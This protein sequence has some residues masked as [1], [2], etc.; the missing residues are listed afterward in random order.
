MSKKIK[1]LV[2]GGTGYIGSHL[3]VELQNKGFEVFIIDNLSNS[4]IEVLDNITKITKRKPFFKKIDLLDFKKLSNLFD[5]EN[6]E[7][8]IHLAALK[9]ITKSINK[10]LDYYENNVGGLINILKLA[11]KHKI[12]NFIFSSSATVYGLANK[13]PVNE[14]SPIQKASNPYGN[15]KIIAEQILEDYCLANTKFKV[16]TLRYFNPIGAHD[17]GLIGELP[18]GVPDNLVPFMTQTAIGIRKKLKVF[19]NNY[20]TPDG[21]GL[22]DYIHVV[23]LARAHISALKRIL[24]N[25]NKKNYEVFNIGLGRGVSVLEMINLFE[26]TTKQKL[27]YSIGHRRAGDVAISYADVS[28]ARREL[29]W[30]AQKTISEA[31]L[32]AWKWQQNIKN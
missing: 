1:I 21:S 3:V 26:I 12:S 4:R 28:K 32:S 10:P 27:N 23:D 16:V 7:A 18:N 11:Q 6:F 17:S 2:T 15:T 5:K 9:S 14:K 24:H 29:K 25:K 13:F 20:N 22:R 19:G 30:Q 31:L 8:I